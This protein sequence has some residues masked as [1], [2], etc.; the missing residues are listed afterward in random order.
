[1][2]GI[3]YTIYLSIKHFLI[4]NISRYYFNRGIFS[5]INCVCEKKTLV[6]IAGNV[7]NSVLFDRIQNKYN[8]LY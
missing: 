3:Q 5:R 1:M 8:V 4:H 7:Y 2:F 6:Q